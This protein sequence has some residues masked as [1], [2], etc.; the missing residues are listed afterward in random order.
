MG[1]GFISSNLIRGEPFSSKIGGNAIVED[2]LK[3][4]E[5]TQVVPV[6]RRRLFSVGNGLEL[7]V[8]DDV[9]LR[10]DVASADIADQRNSLSVDGRNSKILGSTRA[11][12]PFGNLATSLSETWLESIARRS[13]GVSIA[14]SLPVGFSAGE[15]F[16]GSNATFAIGNVIVKVGSMRNGKGP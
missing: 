2:S 4:L 3:T 9:I 1:L 7:V 16:N 12:L 5:K 15:D 10:G 14:E 8:M 6:G 11:R 13:P